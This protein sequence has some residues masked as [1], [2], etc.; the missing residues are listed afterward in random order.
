[1]T[2]SPFRLVWLLLLVGSF[3]LRPT[4]HA[5]KAPAWDPVP[6]ADLAATSS[7][8]GADAEIL[9]KRQQI[10]ETS[11][12]YDSAYYLRVKIYTTSGIAHVSKLSVE[13]PWQNSLR[14]LSVRVAKPDGRLLLIPE[15]DIH[16]SDLTKSKIY[17]TL[18]K[19]SAIAVSNLEPGDIVEMQ[20]KLSL[21]ASSNFYA[22]VLNSFSFCQDEIPVREYS[23]AIS[24]NYSPVIT[25]LDGLTVTTSGNKT[26]EPRL[27]VRNLPAYVP[28]PFMPP[29]LESRGWVRIDHPASPLDEEWNL[30]GRNAAQSFDFRTDSNSAIRKL[31][32][33]L[34]HDAATPEEKLRRLY[35]YCQRSITNDSWLV[36]EVVESDRTHLPLD[37][38]QMVEETA[39]HA[40]PALYASH[41]LAEKHALRDGIVNLFASLAREAGFEVHL[42]RNVARD[43]MINVRTS[44]NWFSFDHSMVAVKLGSGWLFL[45]PGAF[46][47]PFGMNQW[48]NEGIQAFVTDA[49]HATFVSTPV[50]SPEH[51]LR[52][53]TASLQLDASGA[54]VG[55]ITETLTGHCGEDARLDHLSDSVADLEKSTRATIVKRLPAAEISDIRWDNLHSPD[56][57]VTLHYKIRVSGYAQRLGHRLILNPNFFEAGTSA[58]F[59]DPARH[60]PILFPYAWQVRDH[61]ELA[62]PAGFELDHPSSP[63][64]LTRPNDP[65]GADYVVRY[66]AA[67]RTLVYERA[68]LMCRNGHIAFRV[69]DYPYLKA[70]FEALHRSD[71][72]TL[73]LKPQSPATAPATPASPSPAPAATHS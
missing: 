61:L 9:F 36:H 7:P 1:M 58:L 27:T 41:V 13:Y 33:S 37:E 16:T 48:R 45:D 5:A 8:S 25:W 6:P 71:T 39:G 20:W 68:L 72:H 28:E 4:A 35:D 14:N 69:Q 21:V 50:S 30:L 34:T 11:G 66:S 31:A 43:Q 62:L 54:L 23:L 53:R 38:S 67:H 70:Y 10:T 2:S 46:G 44:H 52:Q 63:P 57:P 60:F 51:S 29:L 19:Q 64:N 65:F 3:L 12:G 73:I 15:S 56:L 18:Y 22:Y 24:A 47:V 40:E 26:T 32:D 49:T 17:G 42:A 55:E 59:T